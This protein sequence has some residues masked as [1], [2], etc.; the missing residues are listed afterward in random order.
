MQE[1]IENFSIVF[2]ML[3]ERDY[4]RNTVEKTISIVKEIT[5]DYEIIIVDDASTD[6]SGEMADELSRENP[7]I[8]IVHHKQNR[9]LGGSLKTGFNLASKKYVLY[10]DIDMP[11]DLREI[12][13]AIKILLENKA[14][15]VS[16]YRLNRSEEGMKRCVY[17][18]IY[19]LFIRALFNLK[20]RDVNFSFK[21]MRSEL[22]KE[23]NL[24][25]E[26]SFI[27]AEILIK[28]R[29]RKAKIIQFGT[30]Y[31]PRENGFSRL[32]SVG[33]IFK[34]LEEAIRFRLRVKA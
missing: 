25:S 3:N 20:V 22:L 26:G 15:I 6:G 12:K 30:R 2:P 29:R 4:L 19:N 17:S 7:R 13:K 24:S 10:S 11:F 18:L 33:V 28:A 21:L 31:F 32:S 1:T 27:D 16:A 8:K 23:L 9:K 34:I 14:D 5:M